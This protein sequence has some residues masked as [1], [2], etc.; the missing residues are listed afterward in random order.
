MKA[1]WIVTATHGHSSSC[2]QAI[3]TRVRERERRSLSLALYLSPSGVQVNTFWRINQQIERQ[4]GRRQKERTEKE[5]HLLLVTQRVAR[6]SL[7]LACVCEREGR[8]LSPALPA[9]RSPAAD[10][11]VT[12]SVRGK[13]GG[14][15][16]TQEERK[17]TRKCVQDIPDV[18]RETRAQGRQSTQTR[19]RE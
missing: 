10:E 5:T 13:S 2:S 16:W 18:K 4:I 1:D 14:R 19:G 7:S 17:F 15:G 3:E 12:A 6:L 9:S 11:A 8:A